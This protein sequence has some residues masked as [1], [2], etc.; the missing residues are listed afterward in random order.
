MTAAKGGLDDLRQDQAPEGDRVG[1]EERTGM[2]ERDLVRRAQQSGDS[3]ERAEL[4]RQALT[5]LAATSVK[6][7]L[8]RTHL[9][10]GE[11]LRRRRRRQD[12][13]EQLRIAHEQFTAMRCRVFAE[14][15]RV[16]LAATGERVHA[17]SVQMS[18]VLTPQEAQIARLAGRRVTNGEIAAQLFISES[19]V[20]YHLRKVFQKLGITSR[21]QLRDAGLV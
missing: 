8:A 12:A 1:V 9:L 10:Y 6:T 14:R 19:T 4:Y 5:Q 3:I 7:D 11:W 15:A 20:A 17:R 21:R 2:A 18:D 16:E 13:R